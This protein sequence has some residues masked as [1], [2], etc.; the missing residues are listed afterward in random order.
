VQEL[1][2]KLD[3]KYETW[4]RPMRIQL[5]VLH[6]VCAFFCV[7]LRVFDEWNLFWILALMDVGGNVLQAASKT[8]S[9]D[10]N[11]DPAAVIEV[12]H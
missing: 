1:L 2:K 9:K 11:N 12:R 4:T 6:H 3:R 8:V 5:L 7:Y 10:Q